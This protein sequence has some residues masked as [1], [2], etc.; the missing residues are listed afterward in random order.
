MS[1]EELAM[2]I[3]A[4]NQALIPELWQQVRRLCFRIIRRYDTWTQSN[5]AVSAEDLEQEAL[6]AVVDAVEHFDPDKGKFVTILGFYVQKHCQTALSLLTRGGKRE[7]YEALSIYAPLPELPELTL[8]DVLEDSN[9]PDISEALELDEMRREVREAIDALPDHWALVIRQHY[10]HEESM[11]EIGRKQGLS[12]ERIRQIKI[13]AF[14][15]LKRN[16][17]LMQYV[18]A[19][20]YRHKGVSAFNTTRT[21]TVEDTVMRLETLRQ[22]RT[23]TTD[24]SKLSTGRTEK[25]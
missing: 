25:P 21:S 9:A 3:Q 6:L 11:A 19:G 16:H 5:A 15:Q 1:N 4:G 2:A 7:H 13:S 17:T 14:R 10:L 12:R 8:V 18:D 20:A 23:I 24:E 22:G